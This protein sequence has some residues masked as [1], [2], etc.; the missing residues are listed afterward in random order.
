MAPAPSFRGHQWTYRPVRGS[1]LLLLLVMSNLLLCQGNPCPSC[2]P[3]EFDTFLQ[4]VTDLFIDASWLSHDFHNHSTI[5]FKEFDEKYA[6]GNLY[7]INATDS[8]HTNS[9]HSPEERDKAHQLNN[10]DLSKWTL[11][12]LYSWNSPLC[13]LVT[14]LKSM[15]E[16]SEA[17]LSS[18]IE[19]ENMSEK[20]QAFIGSQF[21]KI[22]VPVLQTMHEVPSTWSGLPSLKSSDEDRCH[23]EL[24]NLFHCLHRDSR[25]VDM[26]IKILACRALKTC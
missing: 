1:C 16:L 17:F 2:S 20:L 21:R 3:D 22:T 5:M 18:A 15:K 8:C 24:Y 13:H 4:N 26:Y 14:E 9:F 23:S 6:Q 11:M 10:E 12:L 7:H 25:K 19:I